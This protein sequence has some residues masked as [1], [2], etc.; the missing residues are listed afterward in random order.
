MSAEEQRRLL[1]ALMGKQALHGIEIETV[2]FTHESICKDYL[3]GLCPNDLFVNTKMDMG[4]CQRQHSEKAKIEYE[5]A[6]EKGEHAG[7][8]NE[9]AL[10]LGQF[11]SEC[12][13]KTQQTLKKMDR[14]PDDTRAMIL[15]CSFF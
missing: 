6:K 7:Y 8:E 11:I 9:W 1:E 14:N 15:V 13:R 2:H 10:S 3:C 12:D 4:P 5:K